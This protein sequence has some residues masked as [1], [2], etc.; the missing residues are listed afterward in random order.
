MAIYLNSKQKTKPETSARQIV[1]SGQVQGVGFR[2]FVYRLAIENK[3]TGWVKNCVG[4]VEIFV[5]GQSQNLDSFVLDLFDKKPPLAKPKLESDKQTA[6]GELK[7]FC[8]LDSEHQGQANISVPNDLTLCDDCLAELNDP[9]DRRYQYPFINCTQCGPR[10]TLIKSLPYDRA[11]TTMADFELCPTCLVEYEDPFNRRFHAEPV[12][13]PVCGPSLVFH[14]DEIVIKE[15]KAALKKTVNLLRDGKVVAVKGIGGYHLMCDA[16]NTEAVVCLRK[17]KPRPDKPL[18]IMFPAPLN[19]PFE[20]AEKSLTLSENDKIFLLQAARPILL[21]A[22]N[23][24]S[25]QSEFSDIVIST[26]GR[27]LKQRRNKISPAGRDDSVL[28][29]SSVMQNSHSVLSDQIKPYRFDLIGY[30]PR[31][32]LN[33]KPA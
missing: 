23:K 5:Q 4:T 20:L 17:K 13:C 22:K 24:D 21:V 14:M 2:P 25:E 18:A 8:I 31:I 3:L 7:T 16:T 30:C 1:L 11:N 28:N 9:S 15:N 10:Y 32:C 6:A 29:V 26:S 12:A 19:N 33:P 27:D